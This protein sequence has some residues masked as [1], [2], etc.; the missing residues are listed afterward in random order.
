MRISEALIA[1][2]IKDAG[3]HE[4]GIMIAFYPDEQTLE[5][6]KKFKEKLNIKSGKELKDDE[7]HV[8]LRYWKIKDFDDTEKLKKWL[9]AN[10]YFSRDVTKGKAH[11]LEK[12]G[13]EAD[14]KA[15]VMMID[16]D[17]IKELQ[18]KLDEG[19]QK[20]GVPP[21]DF[22]EFKC[23]MT[24]AYDYQDDIPEEKPNFEVGVGSIKLVQDDKPLWYY[25]GD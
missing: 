11:K 8:T 13:K 12:L 10:T 5:K 21:S 25:G 6:I 4:D 19:L 18:K 9:S 3:D 24:I 7:Y 2:F 1:K 16:S 23:H 15:L 20:L 17:S 22:P 14:H